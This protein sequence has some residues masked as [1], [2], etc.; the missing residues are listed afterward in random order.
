VVS[1]LTPEVLGEYRRPF[2]APTEGRRPTLTWPRQIPL[3][4]EPADVT[5]IMEDYGAWLAA[6]PIRKLFVNADPGQILLGR[7]REFCRTWP[8]QTEVTVPGRHFIQEDSGKQIGQ[9]IRAWLQ[10]DPPTLVS[11]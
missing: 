11:T 4:G 9:A 10:P 3:D 7:A 6:S 1:P 2:A 5:A 8:N